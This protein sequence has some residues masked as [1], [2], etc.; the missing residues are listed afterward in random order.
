MGGRID[1]NC[2][3]GEG[4]DDWVPGVAG[5][6]S[7]LLATVTSANVACGFHAGDERVMAAVCRAAA[8]RGVAVGA[9]VSY[10]DREHFGRRFLD[11][12]P[13]VLHADVAE[14]VAALRRAAAEAGTTVA[15]VKPHGALY[16]AVVR[17]EQQ[18]TAVVDAVV[19]AGG[20]L[21][22]V[23]LP[24]AVVLDVAGD[25]GLRAVR[26]AF[27]DRGYRADGTLVPR[28]EPGALVV[29]ADA[30]VARVLDMVVRGHVV[31]VD[32]TVVPLDAE[33]VC[34][35]SDTPGATVLA[36]A[37]REALDGAG[38]VVEPFV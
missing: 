3:L 16:N 22:V 31:A 19:A 37:V 29:D 17:H 36:A 38:V 20:D 11:L 2:D 15:Y 21:P 28:T 24:G 9:Q 10:R 4:L 6:E 12:P 14:Q 35:H 5:P 30:V 25:R 18:A 26:E 32:G 1:L 27:A 7:L 13:D 8:E 33:S 23:G 34:V